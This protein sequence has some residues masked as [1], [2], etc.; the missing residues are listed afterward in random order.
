MFRIA[1]ASQFYCY[2]L[3]TRRI[4]FEGHLNLV[5]ATSNNKM[6][7]VGDTNTYSASSSTD[8]CPATSCT[9]PVPTPS[10]ARAHVDVWER[11]PAVATS[12]SAAKTRLKERHATPPPT[13]S[14]LGSCAGV[15]LDIDQPRL[16]SAPPPHHSAWTNFRIYLFAH[17][18]QQTVL[19]KR[20][21]QNLLK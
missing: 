19:E 14:I 8:G 15:E 2:Y 12:D 4:N 9:S 7:N 5:M 11:R 16:H 13:Q 3:W 20:N 17:K 1:M 21:P 18:Y 6:G 10:R